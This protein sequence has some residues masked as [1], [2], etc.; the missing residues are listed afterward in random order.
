MELL[1]TQVDGKNVQFLAHSCDY[2]SWASVY[3]KDDVLQDSLLP[4]Y[5]RD[6]GDKS[7]GLWCGLLSGTD[8]CVERSPAEVD[9]KIFMLRPYVFACAK[10][11]ITYAPWHHRRLPLADHTG[12]PVTPSTP[13]SAGP[14]GTD[15]ANRSKAVPYKRFGY[16]WR[17]APPHFVLGAYLVFLRLLER[18]PDRM[19]LSADSSNFAMT[20]QADSGPGSGGLFSVTRILPS[21]YHDR[22]WQR[23]SVCQDPYTSPGLPAMTFYRELQGFWRGKFLF[24][25][26]E[27]YRQIL[28][29]DMRGLY[30]GTFAEQVAEMELHETVIRVKRE[31]VGGGGPLL[32]AG[33]RDVEYAEG[34][35]EQERIKTGYGYQVV[36]DVD[37]GDEP[38]WTKEML[39]SGRVSQVWGFFIST[40]SPRDALVIGCAIQADAF[41]A[42]R[43]G[44]GH[45]SEEDYAHGTDS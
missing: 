12:S 32:A 33:F 8:N 42:G 22:E 15:I 26:F 5:P 16:T 40:L 37:E 29:G 24:Y 21:I 19:S 36:E 34:E 4:G 9:E 30:T 7:L 13:G 3:Y 6:T 20:A 23:N 18:H 25:D 41:S 14:G 38:G 45:G 44:D 27:M 10:Y 11:D 39:I 17:R 35:R 28:A 31:E 1:L 43:N 2:L